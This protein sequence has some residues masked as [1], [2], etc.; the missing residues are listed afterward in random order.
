M[1]ICCISD[2]HGYKPKNL[3]IADVLVHAGDFTA[4]R[5]HYHDDALEFLRWF[6]AQPHRHKILIAGNHDFLP[7][8]DKDSFYINCVAN[9]ISYLQD[10]A[11]T[12]SNVKF[13]GSPWT[14]P[15]FDWAF[16]QPEHE[17]E[18]TFA[19]I[20]L[21]TDVLITHGPSL[22][23]LDSVP[24][25]G[26]V[27]SYSL[28][29]AIEKLLLKAHVFGHIHGNHGEYTENGTQYVNAAIMT[30]SYKPTQQPV[31]ITIKD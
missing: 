1:T 17:L 12:I 6:G 2:T 18:D 19:Q 4:S 11:V 28:A 3:P 27:G 21:D 8:H 20:P 9:G 10:S 23:I 5:I 15:F 29:D 30:E 25:A 16:M 26:H 31:V 13:Y 7:Y 14:P 24:H 22:G